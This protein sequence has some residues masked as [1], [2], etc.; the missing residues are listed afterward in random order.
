MRRLT[1]FLLFYLFSGYGIYDYFMNVRFLVYTAQ[2]EMLRNIIA[3]YGICDYLQTVRFQEITY[4]Y[5]T[6]PIYNILKYNTYNTLMKE[7]KSYGYLTLL[8]LNKNS[9]Y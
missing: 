5:W 2:Q 3:I 7:I 6:L 1:I 4:I 9:V 8:L